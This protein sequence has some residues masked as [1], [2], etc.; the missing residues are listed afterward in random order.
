[1]Y[2]NGDLYIG[3]Y[4]KLQGNESEVVGDNISMSNIYKGIDRINEP[5]AM[6]Q[7]ERN[8]NVIIDDLSNTDY[9][10]KLL[11]ANGTTD[12][13]YPTV[14]H[15]INALTAGDILDDA[16]IRVYAVVSSPYSVFYRGNKSVVIAQYTNNTFST[17]AD[18]YNRN[19]QTPDDAYINQY[20]SDSKLIM[21]S[22]MGTIRCDGGSYLVLR[23]CYIVSRHAKFNGNMY[24]VINAVN[25]NIVVHNCRTS[26]TGITDFISGW[27]EEHPTETI[28]ESSSSICETH[29][30]FMYRHDVVGLSVIDKRSPSLTVDGI[31]TLSS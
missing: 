31:Q 8:L 12:Y 23:A 9:A 13:P 17:F 10:N 6:G 30:L 19:T 28:S 4:E 1:M 14:Q 20:D 16:T 29:S 27:N 21:K 11:Y 18:Y 2:D 24:G 3:S 7:Y 22:G 25:T 15:A 26:R 5:V